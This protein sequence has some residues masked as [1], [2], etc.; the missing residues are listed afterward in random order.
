M[1][2]VVKTYQNAVRNN[3]RFLKDTTRLDDLLAK[4]IPL[5]NNLGTLV[6]IC[7]LHADDEELI[8]TLAKWREENAFAYPTQFPVTVDGTRMWLQKKLLE[9]EDRLLF[10]IL[11]RHGKAIGH[12]GYA[13]ALNDQCEME[14]DNVIR[15]VKEG[16]KGIM[17]AAM[18][19]ILDWAEE[20]F[21]PRRI[22][23]RVVEDNVHAVEFYRKL[24][25]TD[26]TRIPLRRHAEGVRVSFDPLVEG[27]N[28]PA[29]KVFLKMAYNPGREVDTSRTILTAGPSISAR[30][31]SYAL[32]AARYGWNNQWSKYL[33]KFETSFAEYIGVKHA[34]ATSSC[35]GAL[36]MSLLAL[37]IGTGDE[38][39]VPDLTWVA[40][41]NAVRYTGAT[42]VFADVNRETWC[43]CPD[44]FE[45][46]ITKRTK[47]V[48]PVH[49]YGHPAQMDRIL[50]IARRHGLKVLEDAAPSIGAEFQ[51][52][53]TGSFGDFGCFS[54]QGAKLLVTGEGGMTLTNNDDLYNRVHKIWDQGR[55]PG[56][57][58]IDEL[59]WKYK[60]ANIQAAIGL[61]Q[62]ER[63]DEL[64]ETKRRIFGWY[65]E[66]LKDIPYIT[67]CREASWARSI[68]WMAN[69]LVHDDSPL[70]RE[71]LRNKLK[72]RNVDSRPAFPAISQYK[73]WP[74]K[75]TPCPNAKWIGDH[76]INLPSGL[77]LKKEQIRYICNCIRETFQ[78]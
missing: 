28:A 9:V 25:F 49:L 78:T 76:G 19:T 30:E 34:I 55:V 27:D 48:M 54:F 3:F 64:V 47:A 11:S 16:Q 53:R 33:T 74:V 38:V 32:D 22:F 12:L 5:R 61:G 10:L 18:Q 36:H 20:Q 42:P 66:Y 46:K 37:D 6:P 31:A 51:G 24:G 23:L 68:Y 40:T 67:L 63:I 41:A 15:G 29:D 58:W 70:S 21:G 43:L 59:G 17:T 65:E 62:L 45:A 57:F 72:Q 56:T 50:S 14:I 39:I 1:D 44:D 73:Y 8:E 77:C 60:M 2:R 26:E 52:Q 75:Q 4:G 7:Q 35:T 71:D 13:N 69:I